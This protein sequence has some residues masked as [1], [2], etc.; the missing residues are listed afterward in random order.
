MSFE[1]QGILRIEYFPFKLEPLNLG[2]EYLQFRSSAKD[3]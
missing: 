2:A 3:Q 1:N